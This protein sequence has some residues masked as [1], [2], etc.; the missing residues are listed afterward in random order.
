VYLLDEPDS[1]VLVWQPL[2]GPAASLSTLP[3]GVTFDALPA[4]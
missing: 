2:D 4:K 1:S 3:A